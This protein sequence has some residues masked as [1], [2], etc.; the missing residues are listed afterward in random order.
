M[1]KV[2][3]V[4]DNERGALLQ[5]QLGRCG[6]ACALA[7][8]AEQA[9][10][11]VLDKL[12]AVVIADQALSDCRGIDLLELLQESFD[13][14]GILTYADALLDDEHRERFAVRTQAFEGA[15]AHPFRASD[16][17]HTVASIL[18]RRGVAPVASRP[19]VEPGAADRELTMPHADD[20]APVGGAARAQRPTP[21]AKT[22]GAARGLPHH[23]ILGGGPVDPG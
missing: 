11:S 20:M 19:A 23:P 10:T 5:A 4:D 12:P 1:V 7:R 18:G 22:S 21:P 8:T 9:L 3:V 14:V 17:V 16:I 2:L 13:V 15:F 6:L